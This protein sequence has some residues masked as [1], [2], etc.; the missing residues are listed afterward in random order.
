MVD[1]AVGE[2]ARSLN[3]CKLCLYP[4][5]V[6]DSGVVDKQK[7]LLKLKKPPKQQEQNTVS[8]NGCLQKSENRPSYIFSLRTYQLSFAQG[9]F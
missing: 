3:V 9:I 8:L 6:C 1:G 4:D 7:V 5:E 2:Q